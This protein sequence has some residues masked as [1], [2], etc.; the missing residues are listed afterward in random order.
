MAPTNLPEGHDTAQ[1][2]PVKV[3]PDMEQAQNTTAPQ[4]APYSVFTI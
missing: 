3:Q 4:E 2:C 1:S